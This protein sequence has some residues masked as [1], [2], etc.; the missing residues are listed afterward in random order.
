MDIVNAANRDGVL[1][2]R[3]SPDDETKEQKDTY[4]ETAAETWVS[5]VPNRSL[6]EGKNR[7]GRWVEVY[8][9]LRRPKTLRISFAFH[10]SNRNMRRECRSRQQS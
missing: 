10:C 1:T 8:L 6:L 5:E 7:L 2:E 3:S 9:H 4:E